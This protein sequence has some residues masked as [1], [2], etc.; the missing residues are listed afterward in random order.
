MRSGLPS[1]ARDEMLT[2]RPWPDARS[3]GS[4]AWIRIMGALKCR[5]TTSSRSAIVAVSMVPGRV[6]PA[7]LTSAVTA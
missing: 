3:A 7:L 4:A 1:A 6:A 5:P 2:M